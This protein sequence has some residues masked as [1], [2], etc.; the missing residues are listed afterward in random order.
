MT[1]TQAKHTL[2][3]QGIQT[4]NIIREQHPYRT[5]KDRVF[6]MLFKDKK[7][8]LELYNA[9]N[10]T[11]YTNVED[12]SVNTLENAVFIKMKND[13]SFIIDY[14]MCLFEHQSTYCPNMP[15]RGFFYFAD[16]YKKLIKDVDL[17]ISRHIKIP[18]PHYVVF[19]NGSEKKEEEFIQRLSDAFEDHS[20]GCIELTVRT[21]NINYGHNNALLKKSP[22]LYGYS[23]FVAAVRKNLKEMS[24]QESA[25]RAV[26]ECIKKNILKDF[27][28]EQK[29]E[30]IAMSIYEYNEEYVRKALY[31]DGEENGYRKGEV[32]G[33]Q[34]GEKIGKAETLIYTIESV[35]QNF[36]VNLQEACEGAG[37]SIE[38]YQ[39]A[40]KR[41][42]KHT[43]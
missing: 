42:E 18:T 31:E 28:L 14:N 41:I 37:I 8:L 9:L 4:W 40:K 6:R 22:A 36:H 3:T 1:Q 32:I 16:L 7:R 2:H 39:E 5:Y 20:D 25:A 19:Y 35:M 29:S 34:K 21:L 12:L 24:L 17:S 23:Y 43:S 10:D 38:K 11:H 15:L 27:F 26:D 30:V 33:Y 13:I